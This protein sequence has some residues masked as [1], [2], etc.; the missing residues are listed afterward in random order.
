M[1]CLYS[2]SGS[3]SSTDEE[4]E[5][6]V[7]I[8]RGRVSRTIFREKERNSASVIDAKI[9]KRR[10]PSIPQN[11]TTSGDSSGPSKS[12]LAKVRVPFTRSHSPV[13]IRAA[14]NPKTKSSQTHSPG[15]S[16]RQKILPV[17]KHIL[18]SNICFHT[19]FPLPART[20]CI[21][22]RKA[23]ESCILLGS[24]AYSIKNLSVH[25]SEGRLSHSWLLIGG[26]IDLLMYQFYQNCERVIWSHHRFGILYVMVAHVQ[27]ILAT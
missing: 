7:P 20:F 12:S 3:A 25:V 6:E 23:G 13:I 21:D 16:H 2:S 18:P 17:T 11:P 1:N 14:A 4:S 22:T 15:V 19:G 5:D 9:P 24:L 10:R 8:V 27:T 26:Y